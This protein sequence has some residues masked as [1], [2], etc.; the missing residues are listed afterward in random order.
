MTGTEF[1]GH[2]KV[3]LNRLDSNAYADILQEEILFFGTDA[4]KKL[5]LKINNGM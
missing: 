4:L 1:V 5:T 2:V 3:K